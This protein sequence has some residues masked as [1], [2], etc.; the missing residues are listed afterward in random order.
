MG[1]QRAGT[2]WIDAYLRQR[3]DVCLPN[4]VKEVRFFDEKYSKGPGFYFSHFKTED[5]HKFIAEVTTTAFDHPDAPA[6]VKKIFGDDIKMVC[7]LR[8]PVKR[9]ISLYGHNNQYAL[10]KGGLRAVCEARPEIIKS[11]RY[12]ENL[13]RWFAYFSPENFHFIF[14]EDLKFNQDLFVADLCF[15][16]GIEYKPAVEAQTKRLNVSTK[17]YSRILAMAGQRGGDFLRDKQLYWVVNTAKKIGLK[18]VV[19]GKHAQSPQ[20]DITHEDFLWLDEQLREEVEKLEALIGPIEAWRS[21]LKE[22]QNETN[23]AQM[24]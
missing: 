14:Q 15:A 18:Q 5:H 4:G 10:A 11:C 6:R 7:P 13:Q 24:V 12:A 9:S 20:K 22:K 17:P 8:D 3:G 16:L 1:P 19:F 23:T 21:G 2:S